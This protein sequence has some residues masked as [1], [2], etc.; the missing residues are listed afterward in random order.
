MQTPFQ[1]QVPECVLC[2]ILGWSWSV[3][4]FGPFSS[5]PDGA[6]AYLVSVKWLAGW[7]SA[8][9][10]LLTA[11]CQ[12]DRLSFASTR[13]QKARPGWLIHCTAVPSTQTWALHIVPAFPCPSLPP[14][15]GPPSLPPPAAAAARIFPAHVCSFKVFSVPSFHPPTQI[16]YSSSSPLSVYP[17]RNPTRQPA[18]KIPF[19]IPIL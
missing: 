13:M 8:W 7:S 15:A 12:G 10:V 18:V 14:H 5:W 11:C 19:S 6:D 4:D 16:F 9:A 2:I 1:Y 17:S 3:L